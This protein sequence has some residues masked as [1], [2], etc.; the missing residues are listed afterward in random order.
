MPVIGVIAGLLLLVLLLAFF[1]GR[2]YYGRLFRKQAHEILAHAR[3]RSSQR[4]TYQQI[5]TLPEPVQRYFRF[6]LPD[7]Q[8]YIS[9]LRLTHGGKFRTAPGKGW[10]N[11]KGEQ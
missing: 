5:A 4:F 3:D 1:A 6:A 8:P 9:S 2:M 11:I 10:V 7:G